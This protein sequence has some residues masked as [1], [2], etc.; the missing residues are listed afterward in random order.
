M[1]N[2]NKMAGTETE[3]DQ[4]SSPLFVS[5]Q[6]PLGEEVIISADRL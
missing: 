1:L 4:P 3:T 2:L 5:C 6:D